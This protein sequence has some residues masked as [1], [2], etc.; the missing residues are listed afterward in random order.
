ME[1][2]QHHTLTSLPPGEIAGT[3][4]IGGWVDSRAGLDRRT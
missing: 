2:G 3:H 1:G 4:C